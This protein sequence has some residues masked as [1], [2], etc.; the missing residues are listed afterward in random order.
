MI[1]PYNEKTSFKELEDLFKSFARLIDIHDLFLK[2]LESS[3]DLGKMTSQISK[4]RQQQN[5]EF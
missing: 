1:F 5:L 3:L 4:Q 2:A